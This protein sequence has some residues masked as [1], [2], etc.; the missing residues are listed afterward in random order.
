MA[1][2]KVLIVED[3]HIVSIFIQS[4]LE[5]LGY[6]PCRVVTSGPEALEAAAQLQPDLALMDIRIRGDMDGVET[7]ERIRREF[8]IPV[9]YLTA[10][11]D[12]GT[13]QRAKL[14]SPYG[15]IVK[16]FGEKD[17]GPAIEIA[18]MRHRLER[19]L[20]E[21]ERRLSGAFFSLRDGVFVTD[22]R[23][24]IAYMNP[25]A[26]AL[27]GWSQAESLGQNAFSLLNLEDH[28]AGRSRCELVLADMQIGTLIASQ[29]HWLADRSGQRKAVEVG[30]AP[31]RDERGVI[32]GMVITCCLIDGRPAQMAPQVAQLVSLGVMAS[33]ISA[34]L[35]PPLH[36]ILVS[37][38][39]VLF[40]HRRNQ[41]VLPET[42]VRRIQDISENARRIDGILQSLPIINN[43]SSVTPSAD[44]AAVGNTVR[45]ALILLERQLRMQGIRTEIDIQEE[46]V[47]VQ[48]PK[49][50]LE[51]VLLNLISCL[52]ALLA[53]HNPPEKWIRI[54]ARAGDRHAQMDIQS[55]SI[56]VSDA[57]LRRLQDAFAVP[58]EWY[59]I[60]LRFSV[61]K[62]FTEELN[63]QMEVMKN[64][65]GGVT[66]AVRLP[67]LM[68]SGEISNANP[69]G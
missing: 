51:H 60:N 38:S 30:I 17:L 4:S 32:I 64:P 21:S 12:A 53:T 37:A 29:Q 13:M 6:E 45:G 65:T 1:Q 19:K 33:G 22:V 2:P 62:L 46:N 9:V 42:F 59:D 24:L 54:S 44:P 48:D 26:E 18:L 69:I 15:Y 3:E 20:K 56:P 55:G 39:S 63:G 31:I 58:P 52:A 40:W 8:D 23:G 43:I 50:R 61:A 34:E 49:G 41:G 27:L 10:L 57:D 7:A 28:E 25:A 36:A 68:T 67:R 35:T 47:R 5:K 66:F 16:P 11:E 14:T